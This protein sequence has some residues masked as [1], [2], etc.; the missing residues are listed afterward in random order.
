M[1]DRDPKGQYM[2]IR[3]SSTGKS[4][5]KISVMSHVSFERSAHENCCAY[6]KNRTKEPCDKST[7]ELKKCKEDPRR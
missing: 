3:L 7:Q 4:V 1:K 5:I 6:A 2:K